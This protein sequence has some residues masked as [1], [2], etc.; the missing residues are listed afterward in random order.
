MLYVMPRTLYQSRRG[1]HHVSGMIALNL[2]MP[3]GRFRVAP[4]S[5]E[6]Q[7]DSMPMLFQI[8]KRRMPQLL[9]MQPLRLS[10]KSVF[11]QS[12]AKRRPPGEQ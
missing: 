3:E 1:G 11:I 4:I 7:V 12:S 2:T 8:W 5:T 10:T 9:Q 6:I